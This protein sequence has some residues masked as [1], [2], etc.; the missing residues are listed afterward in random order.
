MPSRARTL[1]GSERATA[2]RGC[3]GARWGTDR[4][5]LTVEGAR[6]AS[7]WNVAT[8]ALH[9]RRRHVVASLATQAPCGHTDRGETRLLENPRSLG[10]S[11]TA[12]QRTLTPLI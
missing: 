9:L 11:S 5:L 1:Q 12:E 6:R 3:P 10:D 2:P 4:R 7:P 8:D